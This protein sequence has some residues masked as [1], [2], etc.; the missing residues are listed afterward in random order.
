MKRI[1][2]LELIDQRLQERGNGLHSFWPAF[3]F[4]VQGSGFR[5]E[6]LGFGVWGLGL[7]VET[8]GFRVQGSGLRVGG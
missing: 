7:R 2:L 6:G 4:R 1:I 3:A 8:V 5:F